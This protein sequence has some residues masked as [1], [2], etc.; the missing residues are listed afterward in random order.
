MLTWVVINGLC[1]YLQLT[2]PN[3]QFTRTSS[4]PLLTFLRPLAQSQS[5]HLV[6]RRKPQNTWTPQS[7]LTLKC[8]SENL[9]KNLSHSVQFEILWWEAGSTMVKSGFGRKVSLT[10]HRANF[11]APHGNVLEN[12]VLTPYE[13]SCLTCIT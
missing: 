3:C 10:G 13:Y 9:T 4:C 8:D 12:L 7:I 5:A 1:D 6:P 2:L 11:L